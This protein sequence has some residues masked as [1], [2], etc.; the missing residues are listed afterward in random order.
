MQPN[1][2]V[3]VLIVFPLDQGWAAVPEY[4]FTTKLTSSA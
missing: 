2:K 4:T 3:N 1:G